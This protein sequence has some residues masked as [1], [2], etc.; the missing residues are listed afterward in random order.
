M[1]RSVIFRL[2]GA[3]ALLSLLALPLAAAE[4]QR[5]E[6]A[7][8]T[9]EL[10][11]GAALPAE[12]DLRAPMP[13][14]DESAHWIVHWGEALTPALKA[15]L[16]AVGAELLGYLPQQ[17]QLVRMT[18]AQAEAARALD[19]VDFV[20][21]WHPAYALSPT[22]GQRVWQ[23][24]AR[25]ADGRL[26]L[27]VQLFAGSDVERSAAAARKLD[28]EL[29]ALS[30]DPASPRLEL[31]LA[32]ARLHD[33]ARLAGVQ[34]IED[35]PELSER[36]DNV[37][38][39]VQSAVNGNESLW[40]Q[41]LHGEEQVLSHIDSGVAESSCYFNDPDGDPAGPDHRKVLYQ[42]GGSSTHGTHTAGTAVGNQ[43]PVTGVSDYNGVAYEAKMAIST[44][45]AGGF[46][47]YTTLVT[48]HGF[49]ARVSTNS[50][51]DDGTTSYT[52]LCRDIDRYSHDYEEGM[53]AFAVTNLSTLK[54][55]ENAK[56]VLAV[57]ATNNPIFENHASGGTGP[58]ADGRRKPEIYAPGCNNRSAST[59]SCATTTL[60]GT[61]MACPAIAGSALLARQ[62]YT[63]GWYPSGSPTPADALTPSGALLRATLL[64]A[65]D[66]MSG[67]AGY[68]SNREGW[69]HLIL[70]E[71][72]AFAGDARGMWVEDLRNADGLQT[73]EAVDYE[74]L[75]NSAGEALAVTLVFTDP[76]ATV[77]AA[78]PIVNNL[79]L[80]LIA[81]D[82]TSY[83]GNYFSA[84]QSAPGGSFDALNTV[85]RVVLANPASGQWTLRVHGTNV[86]EG[87]QGSPSSCHVTSSRASRQLPAT[88]PGGHSAWPSASSSAAGSRR[89]TRPRRPA[90][91]AAVRQP[92]PTSDR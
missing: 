90:R 3:L 11:A 28:A 13:D 61:S 40:D 43:T 47:M 66:D 92:G 36:N 41:G 32:P 19:A 53:V 59:A 6:L 44:Y 84:G 45:N 65:T 87:P 83:K 14:P 81:P 74:L 37:V 48:H 25:A 22:I 29:L 77:G 34:W 50:W 89:R 52:A 54:T 71:S 38:W 7:A 76:P 69:G 85:E 8:G 42:T 64:N 91:S 57:G 24:P 31:A 86:P 46:N 56:N 75:V 82:A 67:V 2:A 5:I 73:G 62:F 9:L 12:A 26:F 88:P 55:P 33:L 78:A 10:A 16:R 58:T 49:G 30:E 20:G 17:A 39:I 27:T 80:E 51:G 23:D 18:G 70:D 15:D 60:C 79:D 4:N 63:E 68:P 35:A 72:L 1:S 21:L